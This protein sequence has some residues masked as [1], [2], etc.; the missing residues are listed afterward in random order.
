MVR[1]PST[2]Q[3]GYT[4]NQYS[5][6]IYIATYCNLNID[7]SYNH[8][9]VLTETLPYYFL[10]NHNS[11]HAAKIVFGTFFFDLLYI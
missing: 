11:M 8:V 1:F 2:Q 9:V 3:Y 7:W 5:D 6:W 10:V 4:I